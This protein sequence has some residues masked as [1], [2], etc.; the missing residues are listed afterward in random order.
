VVQDTAAVRVLGQG[1]AEHGQQQLAVDDSRWR[2]FGRL[3]QCRS[4]L[5]E[6]RVERIKQQGQDQ[7]EQ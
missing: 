5:G 2:R 6:Q 7:A 3:E 1:Q 4:E